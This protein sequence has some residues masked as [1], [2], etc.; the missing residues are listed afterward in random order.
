M[1]AKKHFP[2]LMFV[3]MVG[4]AQGQWREL[5]RYSVGLSYF[6]STVLR[7]R[8]NLSQLPSYRAHSLY[9]DLALQTD[10]N[11]GWAKAQGYPNFGLS[12]IGNRY[13]AEPLGATFGIVPYLEKSLP[14][15]GGP[16]GFSYHIGWGLGYASRVFDSIQ[17]PLNEALSTRLNTVFDFRAGLYWRAAPRLRIA[18][19]GGLLHYSNAATRLPNYG[20][21]IAQL[22]A[23]L[24][25]DF[26]QNV[27]AGPKS[28]VREKSEFLV[29]IT[30]GLRQTLPAFQRYPV[31]A[32]AVEYNFLKTK[33]HT[34][35]IGAA[36]MN[37]A[38]L[39]EYYDWA[40]FWG[41]GSHQRYSPWQTL[42]AGPYLNYEMVLAQLSVFVQAGGYL[43]QPFRPFQSKIDYGIGEG[44]YYHHIQYT[45][46][47]VFNKV[48][49]R[50]R[51]RKNFLLH[52]ALKT[53]LFTAQYLEFGGGV[54]F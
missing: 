21:N 37:E 3:L 12:F 14:L 46:S 40:E 53:H 29:L 15:F 32:L 30:A 18:V 10:T 45:R 27:Y 51:F 39:Q 43:A 47:Y 35:G 24:R 34:L 33:G 7:H 11:A 36:V 54:Y 9:L 50:Y 41:D 25:Y 4:L 2:V 5:P 52:A 28:K 17:N 13:A 38:V 1:V 22:G 42:N 31:Y 6:P 20:I 23:G 49:L 16:L 8:E 48:G 26:G 19:Q 44:F